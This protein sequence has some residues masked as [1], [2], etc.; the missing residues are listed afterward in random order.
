MVL[1]SYKYLIWILKNG[2]VYDIPVSWEVE[3][4]KDIT[5]R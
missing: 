2:K 1:Q 3:I 4:I 5:E